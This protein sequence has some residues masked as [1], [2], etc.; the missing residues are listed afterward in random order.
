MH[1]RKRSR[2]RVRFPP[3]VGEVSN[4]LVGLGTGSAER[5][6]IVVRRKMVCACMYKGRL[7]DTSL[8]ADRYKLGETRS[9]RRRW[10]LYTTDN[11][12]RNLKNAHPKRRCTSKTW[13]RA[14]GFSHRSLVSCKGTYRASSLLRLHAAQLSMTHSFAVESTPAGGIS[15]RCLSASPTVSVH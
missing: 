10:Y 5:R 14:G 9:Q 1:R 6:A 3:Y 13:R 15:S 12:T 2:Q 11:G 4:V 8:L 7:N